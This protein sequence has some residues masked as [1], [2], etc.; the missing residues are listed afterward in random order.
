MLFLVL[1]KTECLEEILKEFSK[2]ELHGATILDSKGMAHSLDS[3]TEL[4]F[5]LSLRSLLDPTHRE[6]KT[7]FMVIKDDEVKDPKF[8]NALV[9][10]LEDPARLAAMRAAAKGLGQESAAS[11]LADQ[12]ESVARG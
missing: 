10:L 12:V 1:N 2:K 8:G 9:G 11:A 7:V 4:Q 6:S 3:F 5:M